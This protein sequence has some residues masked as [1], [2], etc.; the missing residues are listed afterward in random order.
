M[1]CNKSVL[2]AALLT[3]TFTLQS[4]SRSIFDFFICESGNSTTN[5][6]PSNGIE[7]KLFNIG[8]DLGFDFI[9]FII[10]L[11]GF[12]LT[13]GIRKRFGWMT[14]MMNSPVETEVRYQ[15]NGNTHIRTV[16]PTAPPPYAPTHSQ[17]SDSLLSRDDLSVVN[18]IER[19][20]QTLNAIEKQVRNDG[21]SIANAGNLV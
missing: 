2:G 18:E 15:S 6:L 7:H 10:G 14:K 9:Y 13:P 19:D 4:G 20:I 12:E 8:H 17:N 16:S 21:V 5:C 11:L 3:L 1:S